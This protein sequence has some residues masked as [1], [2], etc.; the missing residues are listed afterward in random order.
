MAQTL[1]SVKRL[2]LLKVR[3]SLDLSLNELRIIVGCFRALAYQAQTDNEP[4]LDSEALELKARLESLY[5]KSLEESGGNG[6][7][8]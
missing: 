6:A 7:S 8:R 2:E 5:S 4:Y 3:K 1:R